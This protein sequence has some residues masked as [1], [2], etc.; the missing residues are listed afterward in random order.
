MN[1]IE[2]DT[3]RRD[4]AALVVELEQAGAKFKG[5]YCTC[6]FHADH[7]PSG[8]VYEKDGAWRFKCQ[9]CGA[10]GDVFDIRAKAAG[11][12]IAEAIRQILGKPCT[13]SKRPGTAQAFANLQAARDYLQAKVGRII[14]EHNYTSDSGD[15]VQ[16]IFRCESGTD[17]KTYRPV[18]LIDTGYT[19]GFAP[20]PWPL[21]NL[22]KLIEV[23]TVIVIEG[24][25]C[26]DVLARYGFVST[27]SA[28]GAK[29]AKSSDW[30]PLASKAV[31]LWP[32]ND[33]EGRRYMAE[34][35][36]ILEGLQPAPRVSILDPAGLDLGDKE[37]VA[38][39]IEQLKVLQKTDT[40][41]TAVLAEALKK[42]RA[43][44]IATEIQQRLA[45]I[46]AGRYVCIDWTWDYVSRFTRA[47]LPGT[48]TLLV[49]NPGASKSFMALQSFAFW[50]EQSL[51]T[52]LYEVEEDKVFHLTRALAQRTGQPDITD[53][54]WVKEN[55]QLVERLI[56]D[57]RQFLD[58]FG[59]C[60]YA[61]PDTQPTLAQL[62]QWIE[63]Q[64]KTGCRIIGIDPVTSA[65][66]GGEPWV[67]DSKFLQAIK[68]TATD[69]RC[70]IILI[71]HPIK[72]VS[73][74]DLSQVAGSAAY[75]RFSQTILWL[76]SHEE[77]ASKVKTAVGTTE[78]AYN[79]TLHILKARNGIGMGLKLAFQ[80]NSESL[81]LDELGV[82][83]KEQKN[84]KR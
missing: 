37:D 79:R 40:E 35:E 5:N 31:T 19:L 77:K 34:V 13:E 48:V 20:K 63:Q 7:R 55:S 75:Q 24:E 17:G 4:R 62:A 71:T 61:S 39:F 50:N 83:V 74:P 44:S 21:Y 66:R 14:S 59:R 65:E 38:D 70:S 72:A 54:N 8:G 6:P 64:A 51:R 84:N 22:P 58:D 68:R 41:I 10:G 76:E 82:I 23:D 28:G 53:P 26:C 80:F 27:T 81:T 18:H 45:D 42:A 9:G 73:F 56:A 12:S 78:M 33:S 52:S 25:K 1:N 43:V 69:Y 29:N 30:S 36:Q 11:I 57:N 67:V 3:I 46:T 15:M 2:L 16:I 47:L 49:G 32:D 60:L